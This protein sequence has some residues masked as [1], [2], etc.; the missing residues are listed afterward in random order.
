MTRTAKA[1]TFT[2]LPLAGLL[3]GTLA[4][5]GAPGSAAAQMRGGGLPATPVGLPLDKVPVGAWAEYSLKRGDGPA[6]TLRHALVAREKG[7]HVI[8]SRTQNQRG[9]KILT[10][11]ILT[12]DPSADGGVKK[13]IVQMGDTDP[14][15][16]PVGGAGPGGGGGGGEGNRGGGGGMRGARFIKPDA[17][18]LVGKETIKV[19]AGSFQTEHYRTEGRRGGHIDYWIAKEP[20]PFGLVKLE[21][22]RTG[23]PD[24][25]DGGKLVV[26]LAARGKDAKPELTKAAKPF[27]PEA[28]RGRFGG[29]NRGPGNGDRPAGG[30]SKPAT[31]ATPPK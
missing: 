30:D 24:G 6:R 21:M 28:M 17:K 20:G 11:S 8:E 2:A 7:A 27:D 29:G 13:M 26:E 9:D 18:T 31:P 22:D 16:M 15:E 23:G 4:L 10:R 25:D 5:L 12:S 1:A 3:A 19:A 14:M